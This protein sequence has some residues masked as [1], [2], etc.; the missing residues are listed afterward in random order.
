MVRQTGDSGP[1]FLVGGA[2]HL[3]D[4]G[5]L[6]QVRVSLQEGDSQEQ[7][8]DDAP[9]S[10]H[11]DASAVESSPEQKLRASIPACY[12]LIGH[13]PVRTAKGLREAEIGD[14]QHSLSI[15]E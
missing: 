13:N 15:D 7:L 9:Q 11:V 14:F 3:K 12:H 2:A 10:P 8:R 5:Q 6:S 1:E 4:L